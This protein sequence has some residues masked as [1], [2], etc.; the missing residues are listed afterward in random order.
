MEVGTD[1]DWEE[2]DI[3]C[4]VLKESLIMKKPDDGVKLVVPLKR[5]SRLVPILR[6]FVSRGI[7]VSRDPMVIS[8]YKQDEVSVLHLSEAGNAVYNR[9]EWGIGE[10]DTDVHV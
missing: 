9:P 3:L 7:V 5:D 8:G 4:V 1:I 10:Q 2:T 6:P